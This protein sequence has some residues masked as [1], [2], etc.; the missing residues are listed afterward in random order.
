MQHLFKSHIATGLVRLSGFW[1]LSRLRRCVG[2]LILGLSLT[3]V[4]VPLHAQVAGLNTLSLLQTPSSAR[5]ASLGVDFLSVFSPQ[6][7]NVGIDN[8]SLINSGN[9]RRLVLD[10]VSLF[11]GGNS[12]TVAYGYD[13]KRFG[14]FIFGFHFNSYGKF[15]A[16]D[17][18]EVEQG[19]FFASD[20]AI[21]VNWGLNI[22]SN[23]SLGASLKPV[24]SQ[25]ESYNA[26]ALA[27]NLAGS[28]VSDSRRF[29]VTLQARNI[30][31][32]LA[33]FDGSV[34]PLPFNLA[35]SM[36]YKLSDAPFRFF[37][38]L[39]HLTRWKLHYTDDLNPETVIDPYTGEEVSTP[40]YDNI[41]KF[42]NHASRH[43]SLG[44][45][46]DIKNLFFLRLGY[47]FRQTLEMSASDRT[48]I[49]L[50]GFCYGFGLKTKKFEFS[51]ARRNY[52]LGQAPNYLSLSFRL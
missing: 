50:S 32:Q 28:Y 30:G 31:S 37:F 34:E 4:S 44:V 1:L 23:F 17:E 10:Y 48:N 29:A 25:Y 33:T 49:N 24:Y 5:T 8:P 46:F 18:M 11:S 40:W 12:G 39:D 26:F 13:F 21:S 52:H 7:L 20:I 47:R 22:D 16:Y 6:D 19:T 27:L 35:A 36:S 15:D 51:F 14:V 9:H 42:L 45:E 43:A 3:A 2:I 38:Q 41:S